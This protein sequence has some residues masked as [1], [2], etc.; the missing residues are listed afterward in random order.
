MWRSPRWLEKT[1]LITNPYLL[2]RRSH[3]LQGREKDAMRWMETI[4]VRLTGADRIEVLHDLSMQLLRIV[5]PHGL[6]HA[7]LYSD[8][9]ITTDLSIHLGWDTPHLDL[10]GSLLGQRLAAG[11]CGAG[12]VQHAV[13]REEACT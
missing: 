5:P 10:A 11:L 6:E 1:T 2:A 9:E 3:C 7:W 13:W 12:F 8:A 4:R